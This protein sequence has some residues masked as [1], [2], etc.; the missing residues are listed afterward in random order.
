MLNVQF[1]SFELR[2]LEGESRF[3]NTD[4]KAKFNLR[5]ECLFESS[6]RYKSEDN[7]WSFDESGSAQ[8]VAGGLKFRASSEFVSGVATVGSS[9]S[10]S[11]QVTIDTSKPLPNNP[12]WKIQVHNRVTKYPDTFKF[13]PEVTGKTRFSLVSRRTDCMSGWGQTL[14]VDWKAAAPQDPPVLKLHVQ[15]LHTELTIEVT[16]EDKLKATKTLGTGVVTVA[17]VVENAS[18]GQIFKISGDTSLKGKKNGSFTLCLQVDLTGYVEYL[19]SSQGTAPL[20][21]ILQL[22]TAVCSPSSPAI[23]VLTEPKNLETLIELCYETSNVPPEMQIHL[24]RAIRTGLLKF[25][26]EHQTAL[27]GSLL[28]KKGHVL[29]MLW[30]LRQLQ[31]RPSFERQVQTLEI[32]QE[33]VGLLK[34]I[35]SQTDFTFLLESVVDGNEILSD[36]VAIYSKALRAKCAQQQFDMTNQELGVFQKRKAWKRFIQDSARAIR[37][38]CDLCIFCVENDHRCSP[39]SVRGV[40]GSCAVT[41]TFAECA[42]YIS[43]SCEQAVK[44]FVV[45]QET[46]SEVAD[47]VAMF[48]ALL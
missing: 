32:Y 3:K 13:T 8:T 6:T 15:D 41:K 16:D 5:R 11:K 31:P 7:K 12:E 1:D 23:N 18:V 17:E 28:A 27:L 9:V 35:A 44:D 24:W 46:T 20:L 29:G 10:N 42:N 30:R 37:W 47:L 43:L 14:Q 26:K 2:D 36:I 33:V 21:H 19:L 48:R 4:C 40:F 39:K 22:Y 45:E 25:D 34:A 38:F